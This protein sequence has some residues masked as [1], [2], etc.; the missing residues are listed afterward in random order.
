MGEDR[1]ERMTFR[2]HTLRLDLEDMVFERSTGSRARASDRTMATPAILA[3]VDSM[4]TLLAETEAEIFG[5][6]VAAVALPAEPQERSPLPEAAH[7]DS[8]LPAPPVEPVLA[9]LSE[10]QQR[11]AFGQ[12]IRDVRQAQSQVRDGRRTLVWRQQRVDRY[13]VE[14]YKKFSMAVACLVFVLIGAPLGLSIGRGGLGVIGGYALG[15]FLFYWVTLVQGEKLA[16]RGILPPWFGMWIA[17]ALMLVVGAW[18]VVYV[19]LDLGATPPLRRRLLAR[20]KEK[21]D[22]G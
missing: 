21:L 8:A 19:V 4:E 12:A 17:N 18:L 1:Y 15:I 3:A 11:A 14:V 2:R 20:I 13:L 9:R 7:P 22:R 10:A 5:T 16:D 6:L